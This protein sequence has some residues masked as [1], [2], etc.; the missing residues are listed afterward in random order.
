MMPELHTELARLRALQ[1]EGKFDWLTTP[2]NIK[3][4]I[5]AR[6]AP[7]STSQSIGASFA[8]FCDDMGAEMEYIASFGFE[9]PSETSG[10]PSGTS[11]GAVSGLSSGMTPGTSSGTS[12]GTPSGLMAQ[13]VA[14][15]G[16]SD[17]YSS[18][19]AFDGVV[20]ASAA[21]AT[22]V[23][24]THEWS[25]VGDA[26]ASCGEESTQSC[27]DCSA[28]WCNCSGLSFPPPRGP[29]I[30]GQVT[31]PAPPPLPPPA[32]VVPV[33]SAPQFSMAGMDGGAA[34]GM[35]AEAVAGLSLIHI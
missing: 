15:S 3:W 16:L 1:V 31:A 6:N 17:A 25:S 8:D 9:A 28:V 7:G 23:V 22:T 20:G 10:T 2:T 11:S 33:R 27:D 5:A 21:S 29:R 26:C 18:M 30:R 14:G 19:V 32:P 35:V 24:H 13:P 12:S 4:M 34:P